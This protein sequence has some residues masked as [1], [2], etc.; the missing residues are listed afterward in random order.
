[1]SFLDSLEN[2]LKALEG[3]EQPGLDDYKRR[4]SERQRTATAAPW[5]ERLKTSPYAQT[6][7]QQATRAGFQIRTKVN[8]VWIGTTLRLEARG[9]RFELRPTGEGIAAV[10]LKGQ[11]ETRCSLIDLASN[12]EGILSEWMAIL[13]LQR[14]EDQAAE[15]SY[16]PDED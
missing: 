5:A 13:E 12:P 6:L 14:K 2:S 1:M 7:M 3:T 15:A 11:E 10:F 8:L 16:V 9:H 4:E